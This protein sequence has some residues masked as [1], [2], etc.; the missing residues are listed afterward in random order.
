MAG[1]FL[2]ASDVASF[3]QNLRQGVEAISFFSDE[4]EY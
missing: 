2:G 1:R 3:W 4:F